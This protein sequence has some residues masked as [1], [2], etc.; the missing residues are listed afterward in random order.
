MLRE[1]G[2]EVVALIG[3]SMGGNIVLLYAAQFDDIPQIINLSGRFE[4]DKGI[5]EKFSPKDAQKLKKTGQLVIKK[6]TKTFVV[7]QESIDERLRTSM[8]I[9][10]NIS[11]SRILTIHG[12]GDEI[13]PCQDGQSFH[14]LLG[15]E[16]HFLHLVPDSDH[17]YTRWA[18]LAI[19]A[20]RGW[21]FPIL[22][23]T[24]PSNS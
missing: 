5:Y 11:R 2:Y 3:H 24:Q 13:I 7:T 17:G 4:L 16:R 8:Q 6:K 22:Q 18:H 23:I 14:E 1:Q 20:I 9:C 19:D 10:R 15:P 21:L 12:T